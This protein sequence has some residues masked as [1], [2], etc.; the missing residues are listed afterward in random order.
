M[1]EAFSCVSAI[2]Y[3]KENISKI[4][5]VN[6]EAVAAYELPIT[7]SGVLHLLVC[8]FKIHI[9][10]HTLSLHITVYLHRLRRRRQHPHTKSRKENDAK[11]T[12]M[13]ITVDFFEESIEISGE[14]RRKTTKHKN[15]YTS[16]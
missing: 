4:P 15:V 7:H 13:T 9:S 10:S 2:Q 14:L 12:T 6:V 11:I 16:I 5:P 8:T 1:N 3:S